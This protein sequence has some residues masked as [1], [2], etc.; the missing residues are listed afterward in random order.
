[1]VLLT[2]LL[3]PILQSNILLIE[4]AIKSTNSNTFSAW[5]SIVNTVAMLLR[6][7]KMNCLRVMAQI[8]KILQ[9]VE[10][11]GKLTRTSIMET[12]LIRHLG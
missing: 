8:T 2:N 7:K 4:A 1:M 5:T 9:E 12:R 3:N 11:K 6:K 10:L